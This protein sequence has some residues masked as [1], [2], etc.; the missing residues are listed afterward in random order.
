MQNNFFNVLLFDG[1]E[2]F[3]KS[4]LLKE[5]D[6]PAT[7]LELTTAG[8]L[9]VGYSKPFDSFFLELENKT[10][11]DLELT[12]EYYDGTNWQALPL[13]D[14]TSGLTKSG[15]IYFEKPSDFKAV[16]VDGI[17]NHFIRI[18]V[19]TD[20]GPITAK[21]LDILFSSDLDL[22]KIRE[23]IVSKFAL[24][25]TWIAKHIAAR[26]HIIQVIRNAGNVKKTTIDNGVLEEEIFYK[27]ISKF[28]FLQPLQLRVAAKYLALYFIF[29]YELSDEEG[30]KWQLKAAEMYKLYEEAIKTYFLAL[31]LNDDGIQDASDTDLSDSITSIIIR[32]A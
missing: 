4:V 6:T 1:I 29:W 2:Y 7:S 5:F 19:T 25:G 12:A 17:T 10:M 14:E 28:D 23:N 31:D 20:T 32:G 9:Y 3:N 27:D 15:F 16:E 24:S 18:S 22:V 13:F 30:D 26:D 21:L 8:L 11:V